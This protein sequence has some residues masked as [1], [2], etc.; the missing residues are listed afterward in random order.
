MTTPSPAPITARESL[1]AL[2]MERDAIHLYEGLAAREKDPARADVMR[3][4]AD[5]E[6][7]HAA[8][9]ERHLREAGHDVPKPG[10]PGMRVRFTLLVAGLMG[11]KSVADLVRAME[12]NEERRYARGGVVV[13]VD[14]H[15][16]PERLV[17]ASNLQRRHPERVAAAL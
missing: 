6:R 3:S 16:D 11:T 5:D 9:W 15:H 17:H 13:R 8:V 4:I 14:D 1:E 10:G 2:R 7:R 12:G